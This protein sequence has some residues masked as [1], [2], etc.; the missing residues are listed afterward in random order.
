MNELNVGNFSVKRGYFSEY[1]L[2]S[3]NICGSDFYNFFPAGCYIYR[4]LR[5]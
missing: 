3:D 2:K 4:I 1:W 5:W